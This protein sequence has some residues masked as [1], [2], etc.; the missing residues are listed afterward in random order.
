MHNNTS[1]HGRSRFYYFDEIDKFMGTRPIVQPELVVNAGAE[2]VNIAID[3]LKS[4]N[5]NKPFE[6]ET[7]Q[8]FKDDIDAHL[9]QLVEEKEQKKEINQK[10]PISKSRKRKRDDTFGP[11]M[12]TLKQME[13]SSTKLFLEQ[14]EKIRKEEQIIEEKR[15]QSERQFQMQ[16]FAMQQKLQMQMITM[17]GQQISSAFTSHESQPTTSEKPAADCTGDAFGY[18]SQ[19]PNFFEMQDACDCLDTYSYTNL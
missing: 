14:E 4:S 13:L 9:D 17:F 16:M 3:D 11:F 1:G 6:T 10:K 18:R 15:V 12:E 2:Y 8:N 19:E 7:S 5:E